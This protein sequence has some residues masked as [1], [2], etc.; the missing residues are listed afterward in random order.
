MR[1]ADTS[2]KLFIMKA[3]REEFMGM[4]CESDYGKST[5]SATKGIFPYSELLVVVDAKRPVS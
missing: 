3:R 2:P 4:L 5:Y 1:L